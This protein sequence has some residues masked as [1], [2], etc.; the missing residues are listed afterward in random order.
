MFGERLIVS[1]ASEFIE[2]NREEA[3]GQ[4]GMGEGSHKQDSERKAFKRLSMKIKKAFPR[5]PIILLADS[6]YA[7]E[8]V[9]DICWDNGWELPY[10]V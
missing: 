1:I 7:S 6:L 3:E 5:L 2:N 4:K 10:L 9:M 8:P